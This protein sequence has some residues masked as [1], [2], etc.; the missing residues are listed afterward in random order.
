MNGNVTQ[1]VN[2][3][4]DTVFVVDDDTALLDALVLLLE[5]EGFHVQA[6]A[7]AGSFLDACVPDCRGCVILDID[8]PDMDGLAV[9]QALQ[10]QGVRI[11]V[12]FLTGQG[13]IPK[14]VQAVRYGALG[15]LE[16]PATDVALLDQVR[17][18]LAENA[19]RFYEDRDTMRIRQR[20][21]RL[22]PRQREVMAMV[23]EGL[24]NK[25]VA[26]RLGISTR[27]AEGHRLRLMEKMQASSLWDLTRMAQ[28]C[29]VS[30]PPR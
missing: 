11:P 2:E 22:T 6:H 20:Y 21:Q 28:L 25:E 1:M 12:I 15:F 27:T 29:K 19:R 17:A 18:A 13:D 9:Q 4:T 3:A 5:A 16:K 10:T 30:A 26:T 23:T 14:A 8:L 24:S 7:T